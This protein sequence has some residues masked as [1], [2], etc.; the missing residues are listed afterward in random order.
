MKQFEAFIENGFLRLTTGDGQVLPEQIAVDKIIG[1]SRGESDY[2]LHY[3][4]KKWWFFTVSNKEKKHIY[5]LT[6]RVVGGEFVYGAEY[7]HQL[8]YLENNIKS[9]ID[10]Y[11]ENQNK[12]AN[13]I[14]RKEVENS[15]K[16]A[17]KQ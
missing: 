5:T 11:K 13:E 6:V 7:P 15:F 12:K 14:V 2:Y 1:L 9:I 17:T 10:E 16:K 3:N 8:D 4:I